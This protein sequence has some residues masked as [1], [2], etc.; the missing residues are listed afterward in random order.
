MLWFKSFDAAQCTLAGVEL[1]HMI[2]KKH[3]TVETGDKALS[4]A[5]QFYSLA[6]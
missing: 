4:A 3:L 2:K 5:E 6:S 1:R